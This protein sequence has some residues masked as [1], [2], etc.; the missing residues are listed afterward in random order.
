MYSAY[1]DFGQFEAKLL[2]QM[3]ATLPIFVE[4]FATIAYT[5][6]DSDL[7]W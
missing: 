7:C 4:F 6:A 3:S 1:F 2:L 5:V